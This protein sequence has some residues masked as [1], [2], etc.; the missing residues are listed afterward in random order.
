LAEITKNGTCQHDLSAH[1]RNQYEELRRV[2]SIDDMKST[3]LERMA[4][5]VTAKPADYQR[6]VREYLAEVQKTIQI[7]T[8]ADE[9]HL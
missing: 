2:T 9:L 3:L 5:Y 7:L 6:R 1:V 4:S 8:S